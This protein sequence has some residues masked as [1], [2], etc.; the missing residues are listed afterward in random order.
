VRGGAEGPEDDDCSNDDLTA[1]ATFL[2]I[3]RDWQEDSIAGTQK[4]QGRATA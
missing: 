1:R 3:S 2:S 4:V